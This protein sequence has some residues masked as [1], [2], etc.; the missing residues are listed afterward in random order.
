MT[1]NKWY[2]N[3]E[4]HSIQFIMDREIASE[5]ALNFKIWEEADDKI[6][7]DEDERLFW[8]WNSSLYENC[9]FTWGGTVL[10]FEYNDKTGVSTLTL[11]LDEEYVE[12]KK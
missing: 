10:N 4:E 7:D 6:P 3:L 1:L 2:G 12:E 5:I 9:P 11:E 8:E